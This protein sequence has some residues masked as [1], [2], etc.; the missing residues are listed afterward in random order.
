MADNVALPPSAVN[1]AADEVPYSGDTTKLQLVRLVDAVGSEGSKTVESL[2][3]RLVAANSSTAV[4][5]ASASF[6]GTSTE[7]ID[8]AEIAVNVIASHASGTDGLQIQ[9]SSDGTNWDIVDS[10][11][12][13]ANTAKVFTMQVAARYFRVVYTNGGTLQTSF[14]LQSFLRR[15]ASKGSSQR[16]SDSYSNENDLVQAWTFGS[17]WDAAASLW[18]RMRGDTTTGQ[19]V[20]GAIAHDA[21]DSGNPM[22][23]GARAVALGSN[24]TLV[25]AADRTDLFAS[26]HG[27]LFTMGGH[28]NSVTLKHPAITTAVTDAAIVSAS[29]G[30]RIIVTRV[31]WKL[32][33]ASTVFPTVRIGFGA[34]NTPTTTGVLVDDPG[35]PAGGGGVIG[36]G[37]GILGIGGDGDDLRVTTT[38]NATGNGL[39]I[40][41]TYY[42]ES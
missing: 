24:P 17:L 42:I 33:N 40:V 21:V 38:G 3:S 36:N 32:D 28:P 13:A 14:R 19:Y 6:T 22:K 12:I 7:C 11:T 1:C 9:Q 16:P 8:F 15:V 34:A 25:A 23:V 30:Q 31:S 39:S 37:A 10:Y 29:A 26:R 5:A 27:V 18:Q 4:L 41:V 20:G 35:C 2:W